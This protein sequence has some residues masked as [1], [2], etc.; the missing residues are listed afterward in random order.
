MLNP[1]F[2]QYILSGSAVPVHGR[3]RQLLA[4]APL[5]LVLVLSLVLDGWVDQH[6]LLK[7]LSMGVLSFLLMVPLLLL[8][9]D[10]LAAVFCLLVH[11]Y[12][13]WYLGARYV[14]LGLILVL[15]GVRYLA[16]CPQQNWLLPRLALLWLLL[17]ALAVVPALRAYTL[18]E[19]ATY[20]LVVFVAG[21]L[22][23]WLGNL[24]A[25]DLASLRRLCML[26]AALS[27]LLALVTLVQALSGKLLL[28]SPRYDQFVSQAHDYVL[29]PGSPVHRIGGWFVDPDWNGAFLALVVFVPLGLFFISTSWPGRALYLAETALVLLAL[30]TTYTTAAW[31]AALGGLLLLL[32]LLGNLRLRLLLGGLLLLAGGAGLLLFHSQVLHLLEHASTTSDFLIRLAAWQTGLRV[33]RAFPWTGL[34]LGL[35]SYLYHMPPALHARGGYYRALGTPQNSFLEVPAMGG[36]LL[37]LVFLA[38]LAA[39][40]WWA[41]RAWRWAESQTRILLA[42]GI[43][44]V[45]SLSVNSL[46]NQGWTVAVLAAAGWLILGLVSSAQLRPRAGQEGDG[47]GV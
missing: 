12:V 7:I 2:L 44:A 24:L 30:L 15:L 28:Y 19:G 35:H 4:A 16:R 21:L 25:H 23:F 18:Q 42:A 33:I 41:W 22:F 36:I 13:D 31:I 43:A 37:G 9:A 47:R 38:L 20:Y 14:A 10:E 29:S 11:I 27:T 32:V 8:R 34:G 45:G 1:V 46:G 3:A 5:P 17:L 39:G 26:L 40:L 6:L